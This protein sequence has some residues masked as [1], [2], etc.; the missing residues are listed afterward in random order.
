MVKV[1]FSHESVHKNRKCL[2]AKK[3]VPIGGKRH[4]TNQSQNDL[5]KHMIWLLR[6]RGK[7][8]GRQQ[9]LTATV[10]EMDSDS[11]F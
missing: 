4:H 7:W 1:G 10:M 8:E 5:A 9:R 11:E 2:Q 6:N 3:H